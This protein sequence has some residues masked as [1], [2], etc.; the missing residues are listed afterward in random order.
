MGV[1]VCVCG[2]RKWSEKMSSLGGPN[3]KKNKKILWRIKLWILNF[4]KN[5]NLPRWQESSFTLQW[6]FDYWMSNYRKHHIIRSIISSMIEYHVFLPAFGCCTPK[7][8]LKSIKND[9]KQGNFFE[10]Q[11]ILL[12]FWRKEEKD[13][14]FNVWESTPKSWLM[15]CGSR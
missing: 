13:L 3:I 15:L 14:V 5:I 11:S 6:Q 2:Y 9:A 10:I 4:S 8:L 1:C 7:C 12:K